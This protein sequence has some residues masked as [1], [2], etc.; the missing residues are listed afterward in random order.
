MTESSWWVSSWGAHLCSGSSWQSQ[1]KG[2]PLRSMS[3]SWLRW[4]RAGTARS[5]F[6]CRYR[7]WSRGPRPEKAL[8]E[9]CKETPGLGVSSYRARLTP[10]PGR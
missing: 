7:L 1:W 5:W 10:R 4:G 8:G 6:F 9:I 2:L 3:S